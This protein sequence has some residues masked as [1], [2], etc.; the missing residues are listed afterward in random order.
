MELGGL[1]ATGDSWTQEWQQTDVS[2]LYYYGPVGPIAPVLVS[3]SIGTFTVLEGSANGTKAGIPEKGNYLS[4]Q[5]S[6][7]T[8]TYSIISGNTGGVF[9]LVTKDYVSAYIKVAN[10]GALDRE[11][12]SSYSLTIRMTDTYSGLYSDLTVNVNVT[13]VAPVVTASQ[14]FS[15]ADTA[16]A[17]SAIGTVATTGDKSSVVFSILSGNT[18]SVFAIN[19]STG[20]ITLASGGVLN[21]QTTA[22]YN[23]VVRASDG[24]TNSDVG[25]TVNVT[26]TG[27]AGPVV[28]PDQVFSIGETAG[29]AAASSP[30]RLAGMVVGLDAPQLPLMSE[31]EEAVADLWSTGV[32]AEGHGTT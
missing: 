11:V 6:S 31:Q 20:A 24:K 23:L 32:S 14:A 4:N 7:H 18:G 9:E 3:I 10:S 26:G 28:T 15:I 12:T 30:D 17:A 5:D 25:V 19:S 13:D 27:P 22:S 21:A 29:A 1:S 8:T 2:Q 16:A